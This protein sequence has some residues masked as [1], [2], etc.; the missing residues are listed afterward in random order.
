MTK[1]EELRLRL[2]GHWEYDGQ[3]RWICD[4]GIRVVTRQYTSNKTPE[5]QYYDGVVNRRITFTG[6][7]TKPSDELQ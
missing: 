7:G 2:G 4:D 6:K 3:S 5:Y 1:A